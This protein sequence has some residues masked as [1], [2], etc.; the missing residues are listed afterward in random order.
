M[1]TTCSEQELRDQPLNREAIEFCVARGWLEK[2]DIAVGAD[3]KSLIADPFYEHKVSPLMAHEG[4]YLY[5]GDLHCGPGIKVMPNI[6]RMEIGFW[7]W[8]GGELVWAGKKFVC[9]ESY[10]ENRLAHFAR[11]QYEEICPA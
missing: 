4:G 10:L 5:S 9:E 7:D 2:V 11:I 6:G 3:P 1:K 8:D